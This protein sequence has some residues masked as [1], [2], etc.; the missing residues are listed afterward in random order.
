M[1]VCQGLLLTV[2]AGAIA[3][4]G[5]ELGA[6]LR[7]AYL[8][9]ALW[10]G[11]AGGSLCGSTIGLVASL[12]QAPVALPAVER[13]GLTS[14]TVDGLVSLGMPLVL[15]WAIGRLVD[16][17]RERDER[18]RAVLE[19]QRAL[20]RHAGLENSLAI[21]ADRI[22]AALRADRV[23]LVLKSSTGDLVVAGAPGPPSWNGASAA[24]W[25]LR[26][27]RPAVA[28]DLTTDGRF[29]GDRQ[30]GPSPLRGL[31]LLLDAGAGPVGVLAVER[32]GELPAATRAAAEDIASHLALG[33]ENLRLTLQQRHFA[34]EL[35]RKVA[36]ATERLRALD[37]AKTEFLSVVAHELRT[38]L[39]ALQGFSELL[40]ERTVSADRARRF[41]Q[42]IHHEAA[43]LGRIVSELLDLCRI[44]AGRGIDLT[45]Q[46]V[47]L[48]DLIE[49]NIDLFAAEHRAH[50]FEWSGG[51]APSLSA[52][53]DAVDRMVKNL[54]S[55]AVKYSPHG[56]RVVVQTGRP[57]DRPG[58]VELSVEDDGVGIA[59]SDLPR[60]FD[61]YVRVRHPDTAS[62]RGLGLGLSMVQALAEAH[63]GSVEVESLPGKGSRF[64]VLLPG[65]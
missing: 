2:I 15:G 48:A 14:Q 41:L 1:L 33:V 21:A 26:E 57:V 56:G 24:A 47:D 60:I 13:M 20:S 42:H 3:A 46:A 27:S 16:Q 18:L 34:G 17:A 5:P 44:E 19:V 29:A 7:H 9:P 45:P 32:A 22:R 55:N 54:L 31:T 6:S 4:V 37:R 40:L 49:R 25:S 61:R 64:R 30:P 53:R 59:A 12:L 28:M 43:R 36:A 23:G 8:V 38:P 51:T 50:R 52:D 63:G 10:A 11:V 58:M 62:V 39:T 35:E 65:S